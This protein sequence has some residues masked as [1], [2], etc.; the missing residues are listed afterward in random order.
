MGKCY[1]RFKVEPALQSTNEPIFESRGW[2]RKVKKALCMRKFSAEVEPCVI[3]ETTKSESEP[4]T[5]GLPPYKLAFSQPTYIAFREKVDRCNV[6][7][8]NIIL[9]DYNILGTIQVKNV[10]FEKRVFVRV[11]FD[12]WVTSQDVEAKYVQPYGGNLVYNFDRFSFQFEIDTHSDINKKVQ[13]AVCFE[14]P[15][16][17]H[18]DNNS[19]A[20]YEL[21]PYEDVDCAVDVFY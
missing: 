1:S 19:G 9:R 20:N 11:T 12:S 15:T 8:E 21:V 5:S 17:Q 4:V 7:L 16:G 14:T 10:C 6:S 18:W 13:F 3:Q 2:K